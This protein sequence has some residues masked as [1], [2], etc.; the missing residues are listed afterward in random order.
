MNDATINSTEATPL[1]GRSCLPVIAL[2]SLS[3]RWSDSAGQPYIRAGRRARGYDR[4]MGRTRCRLCLVAAALALVAAIPGAAAAA[5]PKPFT[6]DP[7]SGAAKPTIA[8]DSSGTAHVA[9]NLNN[10]GV[11]DDTIAYCRV[12]RGKRACTG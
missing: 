9:W 3:V 4:P 7:A 5:T 10:P 1:R 12:P 11:A 2:S 8:V 6:L